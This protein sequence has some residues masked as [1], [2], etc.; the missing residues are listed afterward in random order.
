MN[1]LTVVMPSGIHDSLAEGRRA[2]DRHLP[3]GPLL[4]YS[5][6]RRKEVTMFPRKRLTQLRSGIPVNFPVKMHVQIGS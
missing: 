6:G 4:A 1:P 3:L 2:A 5:S